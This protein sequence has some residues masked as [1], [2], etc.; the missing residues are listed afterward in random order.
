MVE[1]YFPRPS[2]SIASPSARI[3]MSMKACV[4]RTSTWTWVSI[5]RTPASTRSHRS[6]ASPIDSQP[7]SA[8]ARIL[9][10]CLPRADRAGRGASAASAD[11]LRDRV[12]S[13]RGR[14]PGRRSSSARYPRQTRMNAIRGGCRNAAEKVAC[15]MLCTRT[16]CLR[17]ARTRVWATSVN[18]TSFFRAMTSVPRMTAGSSRGAREDV[19]E[20]ANA[21]LP[22]SSASRGSGR[23]R[24]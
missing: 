2:N 11:T 13:G 5:P 4:P 3:A 9:L 14:S 19:D 23:S 24:P 6:H 7:A 15:A 22:R 10:A 20:R 16:P 1:P 18:R 17:A 21:M 8:V 12:D